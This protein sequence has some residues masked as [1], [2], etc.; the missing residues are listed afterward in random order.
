MLGESPFQH[1]NDKLVIKFFRILISLHLSYFRQYFFLD[2][3]CRFSQLARG[4]MSQ[5]RKT[6]ND[7]KPSSILLM[8]GTSSLMSTAEIKKRYAVF[9]SQL[10]R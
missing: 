4:N 1:G 6:Q 10:H 9:F 2:F 7:G 5:T 8:Q 3:M